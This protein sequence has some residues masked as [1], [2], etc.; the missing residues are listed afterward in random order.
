MLSYFTVPFSAELKLDLT[1]PIKLALECCFR[2]SSAGLI[3]AHFGLEVISEILTEHKYTPS[4][5]CLKGIFLA[6]YEGFVEEMD[7][8]DNG[9]PMY[10]DAHPRYRINTHLSSRIHRL[11]PEWNSPA[12]ESDDLM[13]ERAM[14]LAGSEF[15]E[16]VINVSTICIVCYKLLF[17]LFLCNA[18]FTPFCLFRKANTQRKLFG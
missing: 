6:V 15:T 11:N 7:A 8:I 14:A 10:A 18:S 17:I 16:A 4:T 2:L 12:V 1:I 3:Y 5:D 9:V 13:F